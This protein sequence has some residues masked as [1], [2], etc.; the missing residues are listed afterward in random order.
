ML[1]LLNC[2]L[3]IKPTDC[4]LQRETRSLDRKSCLNLLL[5][6][7]KYVRTTGERIQFNDEVLWKELIFAYA[8]MGMCV[9]GGEGINFHINTYIQF[10]TPLSFLLTFHYREHIYSL[11]PNLLPVDRLPAYLSAAEHNEYTFC[12]CSLVYFSVSPFTFS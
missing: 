6:F 7:R 2:E 5:R 11:Q 3:C 10:F 12:L 9:C 8:Y 1:H 4:F